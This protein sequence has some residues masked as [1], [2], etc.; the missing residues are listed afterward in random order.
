MTASGVRDCSTVLPDGRTVAWTEFG[1]CAGLPLLRVPGT[2]GSRWT[3][4]ADRTPWVERSL[5]VLTTERPG[6]GA[7]TRLPG[8]G[9]AEPAHDLAAILDALGID[10][11][12]VIGGSGAA[13][14]ILAFAA[15]HPDRVVAATVLVGAAPTTDDEAAQMLDVNAMAHRLVREGDRD[16]L[17]RLLSGLR[18]EILADPLAAFRG[19][20]AQAPPDDHRVMSDPAWQ[21]AFEKAAVE[22]LRAGVDGW[23]DESWAIDAPWDDFDL[24]DVRTS[25]TWWHSDGDRNCP[26]TA[27]QRLV[28]Q[29]PDARLHVWSGTGHLKP[30][31]EEPQLLD[32][33]LARG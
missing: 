21:S 6:F 16:G 23:V 12:H 33:L 13:P 20:M 28:A 1:P 29:L 32:E 27:A 30:Y 14:H 3:V 10:R 4:R 31:H 19:I 5:H 15:L 8:R 2:P 9:F 25:V 11:V 18:E 24:H 22:S 7:S 17:H 26:L